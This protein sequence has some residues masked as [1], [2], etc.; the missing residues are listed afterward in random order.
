MRYKEIQYS[1]I[2]IF[3]CDRSGT[4]MLGDMLGS[5]K[6]AVATPESQFIHELIIL[7]H[8]NAF[9][10]P[11]Q[12]CDWL[13]NNFRFATWKINQYSEQIKSLIDMND[14]RRTI[15]SIIN[16]YVS[17]HHENKL[18]AR[19]WIDHTPDNMK[20]YVILK[21]YFP[22]SR[23]IHIV[24]D[25]RA[26]FHSLKTLNWG[27]N[28]A[29]MGTRFWSQRLNQAMQVEIAEGENCHRVRYEDLVTNPKCEIITICQHIKT[30]YHKNM[31]N[32]GS[33]KLP[34]FTRDQHNLV[35]NKPDSSRIT[36]WHKRLR[37]SEI[38]HFEAYQLSRVYLRLF[39][40]PLFTKQGKCKGLLNTLWQYIH[41]GSMYAY[42][43]LQHR[44]MEG[45]FISR[46]KN[47]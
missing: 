36:S 21:H 27:P 1:P 16:L 44:N 28:N 6:N 24:R 7:M 41:E 42:H 13:N 11:D 4:T 23:F 8:N 34:E 25:G 30:P 19:L 10:D 37:R 5:N 12:I 29:Y 20:Y 40:Y 22:E 14:V 26:I 43:R 47:T 31:I 45:Q 9:S 38:E 17:V 35:G 2:F 32:G 18:T 3:G 39:G 33:L 15:Q 46:S